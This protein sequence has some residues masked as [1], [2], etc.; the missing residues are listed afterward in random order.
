MFVFKVV[1][2][3]Q[4]YGSPPVFTNVLVK[5]KCAECSPLKTVECRTLGL[6]TPLLGGA[7]RVYVRENVVPDV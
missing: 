7:L 5:F 6:K 1:N 4:N 2:C 3:F